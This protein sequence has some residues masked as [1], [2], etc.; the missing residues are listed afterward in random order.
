MKPRPDPAVKMPR[1]NRRALA[2]DPRVKEWVRQITGDPTISVL[3][4]DEDL[5]RF[6]MEE[7][8]GGGWNHYEHLAYGARRSPRSA[9]AP[10]A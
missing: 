6:L 2:K 5:Q 1:A 9:L 3:D 4:A 10:A 7:A 8:L